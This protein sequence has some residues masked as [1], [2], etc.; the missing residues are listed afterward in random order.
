MNENFNKSDIDYDLRQIDLIDEQLSQ[1]DDRR[2]DLSHIIAGLKSLQGCLRTSDQNWKK[3][4]TGEWWTLEQVYAAALDRKKTA[5]S[6]EDLA[7]IKEATANL[8]M[9]VNQEKERLK[10]LIKMENC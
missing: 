2:I 3:S 4:F 5:F 8:Q 6:D 1:F 7:L 9:L 10:H